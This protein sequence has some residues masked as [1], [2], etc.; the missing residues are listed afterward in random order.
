MAE[1]RQKQRPEL[2]GAKH[3]K[4]TI[5]VLVPV[6]VSMNQRRKKNKKGEKEQKGEK[7][8]KKERKKEKK[9]ER[10]ER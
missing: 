5:V 1:K 2:R 9:K 3:E 6:R 4:E 10:K 8:R 7:R